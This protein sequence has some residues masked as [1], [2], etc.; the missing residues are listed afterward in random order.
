MIR[1]PA[2]VFPD[3]RPDWLLRVYRTLA[4]VVGVFLPILLVGAIYGIATK[5]HQGIRAAAGRPTVVE[6]IGPLHG[7]LYIVL[8][9]CALLLALRERFNL[10][11]AALVAL[12]GTIPFLSFVAEHQVTKRIRAHRQAPVVAP[13]AVDATGVASRPPTAG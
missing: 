7:F 1:L 9:I 2:D 13:Q 11:F 12:A 4:Y 5:G 6:V 8:V 3:G 10:I